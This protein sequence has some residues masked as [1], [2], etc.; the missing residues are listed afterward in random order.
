[1]YIDLKGKV[2]IVTG[3]S[4]GI[5]RGIA[6]R[7]G[8]E[9]M[10]VIVNY[11]NNMIEGENAAE[12]V[13]QAGG[14]AIA[15]KAN[16]STEEGIRKLIDA[17]EDAFGTL[18]VMVNNAGI[19]S[20]H[21]SHLLSLEEW[22][23]VIGVN[24]TGTFLGCREAIKFMLEHDVQG[25]IINISSVHQKIP[26]PLHV[27]YASSKGGLKLLTETL[28]LEYASQ[29][30]RVNAIAPGAIHT[31]MNSGILS[32]STQVDKIISMI[33]MGKIGKPEEIASIA[34]WLVSNESSYITGITLFA[35]GG[36]TLSPS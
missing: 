34:A 19:Q 24:L 2:A 33:P 27:H 36:M 10:K 18:D 22:N 32:D 35:D 26:K 16:V 12:A 25:K 5:G 6:I 13:R 3:S 17:A 21:P 20:T 9:Q 23:K 30:I 29:G 7:F 31:P 15:V 14:E 28:A 1:M 8:K 11:H 4:M